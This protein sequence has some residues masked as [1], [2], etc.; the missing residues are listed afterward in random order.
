MRRQELGRKR[1]RFDRAP[2]QVKVAGSLA[3]E[4]AI[5]LKASLFSVCPRVVELHKMGLIY[6]TGQSH[7]NS[8]WPVGDRLMA[9]AMGA[10]SGATPTLKT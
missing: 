10:G 9:G 5:H 6:D 2:G 8:F 7:F 4:A 3:D 1:R